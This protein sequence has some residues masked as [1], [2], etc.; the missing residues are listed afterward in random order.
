MLICS[1]WTIYVE[2][3]MVRDVNCVS[4]VSTYKELKEYDIFDYHPLRKC[5]IYTLCMLYCSSWNIYVEDI[6]VRDVKCVSFV[7]T[8]KELKELL[9]DSNY[10][11]YPLV[12]SAGISLNHCFI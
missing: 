9:T 12:D 4:F 11:T 2:D 10:R 7:S 8:Y 5:N 6:M 3:I 1:L